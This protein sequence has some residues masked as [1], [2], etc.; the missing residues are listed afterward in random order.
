LHRR[1]NHGEGAVRAIHRVRGIIARADPVVWTGSKAGRLIFAAWFQTWH[2]VWC[3]GGST[4]LQAL[5][6]KI[7]QQ[8]PGGYPR[9]MK[10]TQEQMNM[11]T[12]S[13]T[14]AGW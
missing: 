10:N 11:V 4:R 13:T 8:F 14:T 2:E 6:I 7:T 12:Q 3:Q 5:E 9:T 1:R